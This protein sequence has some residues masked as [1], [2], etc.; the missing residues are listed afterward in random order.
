M[1]EVGVALCWKG[2]IPW[3]IRPKKECI[4]SS[5]TCF[6]NSLNLNDKDPSMKWACFPKFYGPLAIWPSLRISPQSSLTV[7]YCLI[8]TAWQWLM[9]FTCIHMQ[10]K[11][12]KSPLRKRLLALLLWEFGH[13]SSQ[14][15]SLGRF[16]LICGG[17]GGSL[18]E[19]PPHSLLHH[20]EAHILLKSVKLRTL[21]H[22]ANIQLKASLTNNLFTV[23]RLA[24]WPP[25]AN[26]L[27]NIMEFLAGEISPWE[28]IF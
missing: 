27:E 5:E 6:A 9:S 20:P 13:P 17:L 8:L 18:W 12:N 28:G 2:W 4:K 24:K 22:F 23:V 1:T 19:E 11:P 26:H 3:G 15:R 7:I 16:I 14:S 21:E 10:I 25:E